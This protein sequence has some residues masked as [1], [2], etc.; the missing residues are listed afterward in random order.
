MPEPDPKESK[1]QLES[2]A[3]LIDMDK[4]K[5]FNPKLWA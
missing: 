2:L 3:S 1:E 4:L 5:E